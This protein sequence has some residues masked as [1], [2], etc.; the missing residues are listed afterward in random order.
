MDARKLER[1]EPV[2]ISM[3]S[4][5]VPATIL[6][7]SP[8]GALCQPTCGTEAFRVPWTDDLIWVCDPR[9]AAAYVWAGE[10][11]ALPSSFPER[12]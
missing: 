2:L 8:E 1:G 12:E 7:V 5:D 3:P 11:D 4:Q 9:T 6:A 10:D